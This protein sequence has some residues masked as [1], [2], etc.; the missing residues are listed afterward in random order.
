MEVE[1]IIRAGLPD[2]ETSIFVKTL[3]GEDA[4][5]FVDEVPKIYH[6][7]FNA[8][9]DVDVPEKVVSVNKNTLELSWLLSSTWDE[10]VLS[11]CKGLSATGADY[12]VGYY[13][14]DDDEG[15]FRYTK[16]LEEISDWNKLVKQHSICKS[17]D[18]FRW[19]RKIFSLLE[20]KKL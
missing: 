10:D 15:F 9:E 13:W 19:V 17:Y 2:V 3:F 18:D 7:A 14:A 11:I 16:K 12:I 5:I 6:A 1:L 20:K 4:P 8:L